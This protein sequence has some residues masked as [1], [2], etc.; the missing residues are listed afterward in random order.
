MA[1]EITMSVHGT[2]W[3]DMGLDAVLDS[4]ADSIEYRNE[5]DSGY[6]DDEGEWF[7]T[8]EGVFLA[9]GHPYNIL[10]TGTHGND[11]APM[12]SD[13]T[14]AELFDMAD[15]DDARDWATS[16]KFWTDL[17]EYVG[18]E[19]IGGDDDDSDPDA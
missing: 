4:V 10:F 15:A 2:E 16:V 6:G 12:T 19:M 13:N 14:H 18:G 9:D 17:P 1:R 8:A 5:Q 3:S 7:A 11:H